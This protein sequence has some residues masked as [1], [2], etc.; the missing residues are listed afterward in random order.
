MRFVAGRERRGKAPC[1]RRRRGRASSGKCWS[2]RR[3]E[4][5]G[6]AVADSHREDTAPREMRRCEAPCERRRRGEAPSERRCPQG[7]VPW[8][9]A[10]GKLLAGAPWRSA[11]GKMLA[12]APWR[13]AIGKM[14]AGAPWQSAIGKM[15]MTGSCARKQHREATPPRKA[16]GKRDAAGFDF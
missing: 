10:I 14:L 2:E 12:G 5:T 1:E 11:I 3:G 4:E 7:D 6:S 16:A 13:S 8:R 15:L 9:I